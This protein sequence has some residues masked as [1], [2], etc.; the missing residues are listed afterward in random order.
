MNCPERLAVC[1]TILRSSV[2]ARP[3]V[4]MA[5]MSVAQVAPSDREKEGHESNHPC[6]LI[7][8]ERHFGSMDQVSPASG[9]FLFELIGR[10]IEETACL[11]RDRRIERARLEWH[12]A[13]ELIDENL[14]RGQTRVLLV[15][16]RH[17]EPGS[18]AG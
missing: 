7:T 1:S 3:W 2:S 5:R 12:A 11:L 10:D 16:R 15:V 4:K 13:A 6:D 14:E 8:H 9:R 17:Q 18:A